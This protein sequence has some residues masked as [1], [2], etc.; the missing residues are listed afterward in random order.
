MLDAWMNT[1]MI[2]RTGE[3]RLAILWRRARAWNNRVLTSQFLDLIT[4]TP[5]DEFVINACRI[6]SSM[7]TKYDL[8]GA[9]LMLKTIAK[10]RNDGTKVKIEDLD[11][12]RKDLGWHPLD[13]DVLQHIDATYVKAHGDSMID[14]ESRSA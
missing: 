14:F 2:A 7:E 8:P 9:V 13:L 6:G 1:N 5:G 11:E 10:R 12:C 3:R 4:I